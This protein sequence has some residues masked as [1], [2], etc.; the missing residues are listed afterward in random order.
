[1]RNN[2]TRNGN[3][4]PQEN[5]N[6]KFRFRHLFYG[7][8]AMA[9][10]FIAIK[11]MGQRSQMEQPILAIYYHPASYKTADEI[12]QLDERNRTEAATSLHLPYYWDEPEES[13]CWKADTNYHVIMPLPESFMEYG[14]KI[15]V[16]V[17]YPNAVAAGETGMVT[18]T[19]KDENGDVCTGEYLFTPSTDLYL[20]HGTYSERIGMTDGIMDIDT[21]H[22]R[23][24]VSL[25]TFSDV[26]TGWRPDDKTVYHGACPTTFVQFNRRPSLDTVAKM[27]L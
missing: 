8:I 18:I 1:M 19:A 17:D 10:V 26:Y 4:N 21:C 24:A 22:N 3:I 2:D 16:K 9:I 27:Y 15:V 25:C 23:I 6:K 5:G 14:H 12:L 11:T 13:A 20:A 7:V